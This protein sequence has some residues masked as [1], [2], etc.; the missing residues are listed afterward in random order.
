[1][2]RVR[3]S[4]TSPEVKVRQL[5]HANGFRY[6]VEAKDLPGSPDIVNRLGKWAIFVHGCFWHAHE[7]CHLWTI[8]KS[9]QEFW[10][11]KFKDNRN[12]D[13]RKLKELSKLG[14]SVLVIWQC[15]LKDEEKLKRKI[16]RF[17]ERSRSKKTEKRASC[18]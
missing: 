18:S 2:S 8:P 14:Y 7:N 4:G 16:L 12:R 5:L 10:V 13:R 11:K 9:N 3:H 1:M 15:D 6:R 17:E